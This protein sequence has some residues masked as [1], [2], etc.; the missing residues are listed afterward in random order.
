MCGSV[1]TCC[2]EDG[3]SD[4]RA[5]DSE[6]SG[7]VRRESGNQKGSGKFEGRVKIRRGG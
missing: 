4:G 5:G 1:P 7:G 6:G 2:P 3:E